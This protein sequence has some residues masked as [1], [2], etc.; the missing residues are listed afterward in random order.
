MTHF[1]TCL[2]PKAALL[3]RRALLL[4]VALVVAGCAQLTPSAAPRLSKDGAAATASYPVTEKNIAAVRARALDTVNNTR[5]SA[6]LPPVVLDEALNAAAMRQSASMS[7]QRR[8][9]AFGEDGSSPVHRAAQAGFDGVLL[10]EMVSETYETEVRAIATWAGKE[11]LRAILLD[12]RATR[13]GLGAHQDADQK[14]WWTL[15]IGM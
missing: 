9:W 5:A 4:A 13:I 12:P 6:G 14:L 11:D 10:G 15:S 3:P 1:D 8:A 2:R 7:R